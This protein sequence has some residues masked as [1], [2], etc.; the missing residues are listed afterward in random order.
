MGLD[1][2]NQRPCDLLACYQGKG[3]E[4][5]GP[6]GAIPVEIIEKKIYLLRSQK[7]MLSTDLARLYQVE[8]RALLRALKR[9]RDRFHVS[10][11]QGG[12]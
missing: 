10:I 1:Q 11:D 2:R 3:D 8:T 4:M 9:N 7:V 6:E 5:T 12:I